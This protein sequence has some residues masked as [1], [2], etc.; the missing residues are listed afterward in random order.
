V[1]VALRERESAI[2]DLFVHLR[3]DKGEDAA[4]NLKLHPKFFSDISELLG[5]NVTPL[6]SFIAKDE[7]HKALFN[8]EY[9]SYPETA[10][11]SPL[12]ERLLM[13][14]SSSH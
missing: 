9:A 12:L 6:N 13:T 14:I 11:Q 7:Q 4:L 2:K 8:E 3:E 5:F 10:D 1:L